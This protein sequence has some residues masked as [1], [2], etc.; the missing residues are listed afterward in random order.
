MNTHRIARICTHTHTHRH[1][2]AKFIMRLCLKSTATASSSSSSSLSLLFFWQHPSVNN[3]AE[4]VE[5]SGFLSL[6]FLFLSVLSLF[7]LLLLLLFLPFRSCLSLSLLFSFYFSLHLL[8]SIFSLTAWL[9]LLKKERI[10]TSLHHFFPSSFDVSYSL[11]VGCLFNNRYFPCQSLQSCKYHNHRFY[12][13]KKT[14][15]DFV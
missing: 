4:I 8:F 13:I 7:L 10:S 1:T 15:I 6:F 2:L 11:L 14:Q 9:S 5:M 3:Q 12:S